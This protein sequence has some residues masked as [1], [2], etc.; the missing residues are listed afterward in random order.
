MQKIPKQLEAKRD[1]M[2]VSEDF[3]MIY[4]NKF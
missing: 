2:C 4:L 1:E 3:D